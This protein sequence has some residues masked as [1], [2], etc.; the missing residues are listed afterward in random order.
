MQNQNEKKE[1]NGVLKSTDTPQLAEKVEKIA[2][3]LGINPVVARLLYNRGYQDEASA[4]SFIYMESEMLSDPF[5]MKDIDA[6]ID[7]IKAAVDAGE[8]ITVYGDDTQEVDTVGKI[9]VEF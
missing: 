2:S 8:K 1:K 5:K 6:A 3:A 4:K 9:T 7:G